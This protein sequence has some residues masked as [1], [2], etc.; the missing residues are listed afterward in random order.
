[1]PGLPPGEGFDMQP[2]IQSEHGYR[3]RNRLMALGSDR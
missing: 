1:M 3:F 2:V